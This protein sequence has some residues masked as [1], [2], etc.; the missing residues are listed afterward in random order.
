[1]ANVAA[2]LLVALGLVGT[3]LSVAGS[4]AMGLSI[5]LTGVVFAAV[6][7]VTAQVTESGRS[8][9]AIAAAGLGA[10][11]LLRAVG[12]TGPA[13]LSWLS[14]LGWAMRMRPFAGELWWVPALA[15]AFTAALAALA[16]TLAGHRDLNA[17]LLP[18][19]SGRAEAAPGLRS[20]LALAWRLHRGLL[21]GWVIGM[22]LSGAVLGGAA[23]GLSH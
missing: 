22:A 12:D 1:L 19:R 23:N 15:V 10:A 21:I 4:V 16:Y 6:A 18:Q 7:A 5:G 9:T 2:A 8:A 13:W 11:Y 20:P 3:G 17:G 14:P